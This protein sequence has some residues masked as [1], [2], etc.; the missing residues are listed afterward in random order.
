MQK[1]TIVIHHTAM[2]STNDAHEQFDAVNLAHRRRWGGK[3][4]SSMGFYGGYHYIIERNG[5]VQQFRDETEDGAHCN[6][7]LKRI[8][9]W[10]YSANSY[11]IGVCFAGNMS[12]QQLTPEQLKSGVELIK[13]IR[14]RRSIT[15]ANILPHRNFKATQCPGNNIPDKVWPHLQEQY[16]KLD[17]KEPEIIKWHKD[18][19]IIEKWS[20]PP[21]KEELKLGWT[22]YKAL[23]A[24][25]ENKLT[26]KL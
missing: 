24:N 11:A 10:V 4:K 25:K 18:N 7:G 17:E 3:T 2:L 15:D 23:K 20:K 6:T 16:L 1:D 21:T 14:D 12:V 13:D 5:T 19:K 9:A 8:G 22:V 26:F